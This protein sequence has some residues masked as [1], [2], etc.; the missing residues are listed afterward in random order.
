M[1][2][3]DA[4]VVVHWLIPGIFSESSSALLESEHRFLAP[5]LLI[6]EVGNAVWKLHRQKLL[7]REEAETAINSLAVSPIVLQP[8]VKLISSAFLI[9]AEF[10]RSVYDS[11]YLAL[12]LS[13]DGPF[14]TADR[15]LLNAVARTTVGGHV[16]WIDDWAEHSPP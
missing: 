5:D 2:V 6:A 8:S 1:I 7:S 15:K 10:D 4:S 12:A 11:L 3:V 16:I 14:I 13:I 9:A